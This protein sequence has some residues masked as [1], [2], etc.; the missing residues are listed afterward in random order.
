MHRNHSGTAGDDGAGTDPRLPRRS[1]PGHGSGLAD[2]PGGAALTSRKVTGD[3]RRYLRFDVLGALSASLSSTETLRV[4]NLGVRGAL[5]EAA[6][7]LQADTHYS[8][9]FVLHSHISDVLVRIRRVTEVQREA[10]SAKYLI[11]LE[12]LTLSTEAEETIGRLVAVTG[13]DA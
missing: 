8:M 10:S 12:F 5:V 13:A 4:L 1:E 7:P 2:Y 9:R 6:M 11:G 3:R